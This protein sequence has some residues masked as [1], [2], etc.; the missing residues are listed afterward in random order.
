MTDLMRSGQM[1]PADV[2]VTATGADALNAPPPPD[3]LPLAPIPS[4]TPPTL[5]LAD[6]QSPSLLDG[7]SVHH[8]ATV[9]AEADEPPPFPRLDDTLATIVAD[10]VGDDPPGGDAQP[11]RGPSDPP[12]SP[13]SLRPSLRPSVQDDPSSERQSLIDP[14]ELSAIVEPHRRRLEE[15]R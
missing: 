4:S 13:P 9:L 2:A 10:L 15:E 12:S 5:P 14:T 3:A 6:V 1:P 11:S 8:K 7:D